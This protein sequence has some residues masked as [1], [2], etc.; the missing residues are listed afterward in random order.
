[1]PHNSAL[2][3]SLIGLLAAVL[4]AQPSVPAETAPLVEHGEGRMVVSV[5]AAEGRFTVRLAHD[6]IIHGVRFELATA[7]GEPLLD[8]PWE[9]TLAASTVL[10]ADGTVALLDDGRPE[11]RVPRPYG[12]RFSASDSMTISH[13]MKAETG[14]EGAI[15]R[16][17][18]EY[19]RPAMRMSR[20]PVVALAL[21][22]PMASDA[23]DTWTWQPDVDGRLV[24]ISGRELVGAESIVLEDAT[25]GAVLWHT[26]PQRT[27][28]GDAHGSAQGELIR[29]SIT[30]RQGRSYRLRA[31]FSG[32]R[33]RRGASAPLAVLVPSL[34]RGE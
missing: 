24:A 7:A 16:L 6:A 8:L 34:R 11:L 17:T 22:P 25:T 2:L 33:P 28:A 13:R 15:L 14:T 32:Q 9:A 4:P 12:L 29:P 26:E 10:G 30:L 5:G 27:G 1:M 18:I 23:V 31:L 3:L 20:L 21:R 19:E